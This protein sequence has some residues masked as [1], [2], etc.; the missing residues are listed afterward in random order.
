MFSIIYYFKN[1]FLDSCDVNELNCNDD[2]NKQ[3]F[4]VNKSVEINVD[5]D[6]ITSGIILTHNI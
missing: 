4:N 3:L 2:F 1:Y 5:N 6:V